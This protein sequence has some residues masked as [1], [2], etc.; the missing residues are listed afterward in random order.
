[1]G[2]INCDQHETCGERAY[3]QKD[4][5]HAK[6]EEMQKREREIERPP[7]RGHPNKKK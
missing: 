5:T 1:M 2:E 3:I 4:S 6:S 7:F